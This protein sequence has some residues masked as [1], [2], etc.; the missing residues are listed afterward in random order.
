MLDARRKPVLLPRQ[1]TS[2]HIAILE[3]WFRQ[4]HDCKTTNWRV[5]NEPGHFGCEKPPY[6]MHPCNAK[7]N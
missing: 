6:S 5:E 1:L 2:G 4:G 3:A 7:Q